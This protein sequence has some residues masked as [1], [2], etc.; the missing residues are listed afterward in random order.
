MMVMGCEIQN[1]IFQ[2]IDAFFSQKEVEIRTITTP[3]DLL[4]FVTVMKGTSEIISNAFNKYAD[5]NGTIKDLDETEAEEL[6]NRIIERNK[7]YIEI[8]N[9]KC[10][11]IMEPYVVQI[12]EL[13]NSISQ[14]YKLNG[15][16]PDELFKKYIEIMGTIGN[17]AN[18]LTNKLNDRFWKADKTVT[19]TLNKKIKSQ[20]N[21]N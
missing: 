14:S 20:T 1:K 9:A 12:E 3:E 2:E 18:L 15:I 7:V 11:E 10:D 13:A 8:E 6:M 16:I 21:N 17:Y 19:K 5:E 4:E